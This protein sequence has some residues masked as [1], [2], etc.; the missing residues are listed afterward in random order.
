MIFGTEKKYNPA[1][2]SDYEVYEV[3]MMNYGVLRLKF[4][5]VS[6]KCKLQ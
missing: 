5:V 4:C 2:R 6:S 3:V 1:H